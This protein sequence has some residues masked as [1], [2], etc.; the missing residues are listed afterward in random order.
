MGES[1]RFLDVPVGGAEVYVKDKDRSCKAFATYFMLRC[2]KMLKYD[3]LPEELPVDCISKILLSNGWGW[4]TKWYKDKGSDNI[5]TTKQLAGEEQFYMFDGTLG[6]VPDA[7]YRPT[8]LIVAN[9]GSKCYK[10]F[11]LNREKNGTYYGDEG[12]IIRND[13][14]ICTLTLGICIFSLS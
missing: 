9:P 11:T 10:D 1:Y 3:G 4:F 6:G 5:V 14:Y 12:V 2:M 8:K 7:Y 13:A